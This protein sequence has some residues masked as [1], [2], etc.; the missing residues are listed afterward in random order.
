[1]LSHATSS[2]HHK[3][4]Q[5][6]IHHE[7]QRVAPANLPAGAVAGGGKGDDTKNLKGNGIENR[8]IPKNYTQKSK[9]YR[10]SRNPTSLEWLTRFMIVFVEGLEI[11]ESWNWD[12]PLPSL[13]TFF[14][15]QWTS[16]KHQV[17]YVKILYWYYQFKKMPTKTH[18]H[19]IW[20]YIIRYHATQSGCTLPRVC[21]PNLVQ[22]SQKSQP[23]L[24]R[25]WRGGQMFRY[26]FFVQLLRRRINFRNL[27]IVTSFLSH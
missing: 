2:H 15:P 9:K 23:F 3:W 7:N 27:R 1:M 11:L 4:N 10:T 5:I 18:H 19:A 13:S 16:T 6:E 8:E 21:F 14:V 24:L 20:N 12:F 17:L 25:I 26:H 22:Y